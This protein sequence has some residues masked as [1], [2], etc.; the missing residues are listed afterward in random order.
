MED[1]FTL[2]SKTLIDSSN[3]KT[4]VKFIKT[5]DESMLTSTLL[6]QLKAKQRYFHVLLFEF[7]SVYF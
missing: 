6:F 7:V 1:I 5:W 4:P 2:S 3:V